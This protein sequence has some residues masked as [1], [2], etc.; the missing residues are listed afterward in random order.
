MAETEDKVRINGQVKNLTADAFRFYVCTGIISPVNTWNRRW[1]AK[2][3]NLQMTIYYLHN[4]DLAIIL[5][6]LKEI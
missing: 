1:T 5:G 2:Y 6:I 3:L 4:W